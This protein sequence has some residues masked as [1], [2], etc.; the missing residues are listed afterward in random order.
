[1]FCFR[2]IKRAHRVA[3]DL[4]AGALYVNNYNIFPCEIPFGGYKK[5]GIGRENGHAAMEYYSQ[6]KSVYIEMND[7]WCPY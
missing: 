6:L 7:V 5:S 1:M 4:Q 2:D 3:A